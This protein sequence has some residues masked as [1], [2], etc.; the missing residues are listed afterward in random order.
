VG[1]GRALMGG[2]HREQ[3]AERQVAGGAELPFG[4][5]QRVCRAAGQLRGEFGRPL[6][7]PV[8]GYHLVEQR[9]LE[10]LR[11]G[12]AAAGGDTTATMSWSFGDLVAYASRGTAAWLSRVS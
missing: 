9:L 11:R 8:G 7:E 3:R 4:E 12:E 1:R 2:L 10:S 5:H 6:G